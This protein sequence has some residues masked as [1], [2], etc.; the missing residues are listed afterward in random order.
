[1]V[2]ELIKYKRA[3]HT[4]FWMVCFFILF[5][6]FTQDFYNGLIDY[7]HTGL[8]IIPLITIVYLNRRLM[9]YAIDK[10]SPGQYILGVIV[11]ILI[12]V[13]LHFL[14]YNF[15]TDL[16]FKGFF[17]ASYFTIL[18]VA[19]YSLIFLFLTSVLKLAKDWF[20]V[21][22]R[23]I[24]LVQ[25][26][27]QVQLSSLKS[28]INPHF[29]FNSLNNIYSLS[30]DSPGSVRNYILK[31]SD[32]LRYM[33]YETDEDKVHLQA[34][35]TYLSDYIALEKLRMSTPEAV[36]YRYPENTSELIAPL[37]LLPLVENCFKHLNKQDPKIDINVMLE[38]TLLTITT[39]NTFIKPPPKA[40]G[41]LGLDNL[42]KRLEL[43]Y[44]KK[45]EL[46]T[47]TNNGLY[48]NTLKIDLRP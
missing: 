27:H 6:L 29:L 31:L 38:D 37:L 42:K 11:L 21:K 13:G 26:N 33:L 24:Q 16:V 30:T 23:E 28:Q 1:M 25:E 46:I 47:K 45:Y 19:Q 5:R 22:D 15:L 12:G 3:Y 9:K 40:I 10:K 7:I 36:S 14:I 35:L 4:I 43:L 32:A 20:V 34:E 48:H 41:G 44:P 17:I 39:I 2:L 8:F 18:E